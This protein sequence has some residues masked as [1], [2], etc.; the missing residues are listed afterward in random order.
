MGGAHVE[1]RL[2]GPNSVGWVFLSEGIQKFSFPQ[3]LGVDRFVTIG[4]PWPQVMA[5]FVGAVEIVCGALSLL[6]L[7]TRLAAVPLLLYICVAL[8][9]TKVITMAK[10]GL[11]EHA[12]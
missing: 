11:L 10:N 12:A 1:G 3:A 5:P 7:L 6:G 4:I 2:A 8:Y 9:S